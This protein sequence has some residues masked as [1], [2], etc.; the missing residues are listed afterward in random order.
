MCERVISRPVTTN[1]PPVT[2]SLL[3]SIRDLQPE[4]DGGRVARRGFGYQDH[5]AAGYCLDMLT[6]FSLLEIWC[7]RHDD[8]NRGCRVG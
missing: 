1:E 3:P 4:E 8:I 7:E 2:E 5:V 6:D